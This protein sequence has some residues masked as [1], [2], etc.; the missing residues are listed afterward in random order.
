MPMIYYV[1]DDA[2]ILLIL[3]L[4]EFRFGASMPNS[5]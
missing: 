2:V 5:S 3:L 1:G 4:L